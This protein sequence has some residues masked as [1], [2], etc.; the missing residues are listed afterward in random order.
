MGQETRYRIE[1]RKRAGYENPGH[2]LV[3]ECRIDGKRYT[4]AKFLRSGLRPDEFELREYIQKYAAELESRLEERFVAQRTALFSWKY[5]P[6]ELA[7]EL[8]R[9]R[10]QNQVM[11]EVLSVDEAAWY[12]REFE[13]HYVHGTTAVE[14]NTLSLSDTV[15]LLEHDVIPKDKSLR[16]IYEVRNFTAV[17]AYRNSHRGKVDFAFIKRLHKL[18]TAN[19]LSE[20]GKFRVSDGFAISGCD[21]QLTPAVLIEDELSALISQY[22]AQIES[23]ANPFECAVLF[24]YYFESIH[25]FVDG[26]GRVG[27]ELL[28]YLLTRSGY[29]RFLVLGEK[30]GEYLS[31]LRMGNQ[32]DF[33]GM[34]SAFCRM[35]LEQRAETVRANMEEGLR[36][37][38]EEKPRYVRGS[39]R[40]FF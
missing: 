29:P 38:R 15:S 12:E 20:P 34:V 17:A 21:F 27:R 16:E 18:I 25:P 6:P 33:S 24:H 36:V 13:Y 4:A 11:H 2:Y 30:R 37:L 26:N 10:Y 28:N 7:A 32:D 8:E 5:L 31:A 23:G 40:K 19:I 9:L 1:S 14:G 3:R 39:V 22:Y 35:M